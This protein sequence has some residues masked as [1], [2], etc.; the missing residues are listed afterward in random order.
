MKKLLFLMIS[1]TASVSLMAQTNSTSLK[2]FYLEVGT[3]PATH[4]GA[5]GFVGVTAVLKSNWTASLSYYTFDMDAKHIPSD[6]E[7]GYES[8][9]LISFPDPMPT[10]N[11]RAFNFTAGRFFQLGRTT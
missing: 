5:F 3:G 4:N 1:F 6:Y 7:P 2:K 9:G 8:I 11:L 10:A